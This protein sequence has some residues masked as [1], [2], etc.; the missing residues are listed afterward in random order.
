M[1]KLEDGAVRLLQRLVDA[2]KLSLISVDQE[3]CEGGIVAVLKS[4]LCQ[5]N[6]KGVRVDSNSIGPWESGVV[7]ELL[8]FW[9]QNSDKLR[10]KRLV[11]EGF[12]KGGVKQ[13]E[14]FLLPS[15]CA[16]CSMCIFM[17][18]Y[19]T[20]FELRGILKVCSKEERGAISREF[21]HEQMRFYKPSCI[22]KFEEGKGSER[23]RLY[24]SFEC[25][26]PKDQLTGLPELAANHKGL[27]RLG[28][29]QR[30]TSV[31]V[32]FG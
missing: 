28:L 31:Q 32:L 20:S 18:R 6:F 19:F 2:R 1:K 23:R 3:T 21:Q 16:P 17:E 13:L 4:L 25:A 10:G 15:V 8:H 29:M 9:S 14:K 30:A 12:C 5:D 11:L 24:I 26:N 22:F 7:R 27:D